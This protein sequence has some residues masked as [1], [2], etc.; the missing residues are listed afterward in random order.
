M[1]SEW[2]FCCCIQSNSEPARAFL[3]ILDTIENPESDH[4]LLYLAYRELRKTEISMQG[5]ALPYVLESLH[6]QDIPEN[7][8]SVVR[9]YLDGLVQLMG[10]DIRHAFDSFADT[11]LSTTLAQDGWATLADGAQKAHRP[12][13]QTFAPTPTPYVDMKEFI[14]ETMVLAVLLDQLRHS[15]DSA[16]LVA[17]L[18]GEEQ[19]ASPVKQLLDAAL[20]YKFGRLPFRLAVRIVHV[21]EIKPRSDILLLIENARLSVLPLEPDLLQDYAEILFLGGSIQTG[22]APRALIVGD[23]VKAS[24]D[25]RTPAKLIAGA[26][27]GGKDLDGPARRIVQLP[28]ESFKRNLPIVYWQTTTWDLACRIDESATAAELAK[29][30]QWQPLAG[31]AINNASDSRT[32]ERGELI[33]RSPWLHLRLYKPIR[34]GT[35][36]RV[37]PNASK[38]EDL[39][40]LISAGLTSVRILQHL[41]QDSPYFAAHALLVVHSSD[42]LETAYGKWLTNQKDFTGPPAGRLSQALTALALF[43]RR[44][45]GFVGR[46]HSRSVAPESFARLLDSQLFAS[47]GLPEVRPEDRDAF[48]HLVLLEQLMSWIADAFPGV[49]DQ[50]GPGRWIPLIPDVYEAF[51]HTPHD[52]RERLEAA[53]VVRFVCPDYHL[54][55][56]RQLRWQEAVDSHNQALEWM[57]LHRQILLTERDLPPEEWLKKEWKDPDWGEVNRHATH[58]GRELERLASLNRSSHVDPSILKAWRNDW[59]G[60]LNNVARPRELDRFIR[61]R[62]LELMDDPILGNSIEDQEFIALVLMEFGALYEIGRM[63]NSVYPVQHEP[64]NAPL[65]E[66][67]RQ[68]QR[69][70]IHVMCKEL[71]RLGSAPTDETARHVARD[72]RQAV[73]DLERGTLIEEALARVA[74][75]GPIRPGPEGPESLRKALGDARDEGRDQHTRQMRELILNIE[76]ENGQR[77]IASFPRGETKSYWSVQAAICDPNMLTAT[78]VFDQ[79]DTEGAVNLFESSKQEVD[80]FLRVTATEE[81]RRVVGVVVDIEET[82]GRLKYLFNIGVYFLLTLERDANRSLNLGQGDYVAL[83]VYPS[84][85]DPRRRAFRVDDTARVARLPR[86]RL[87]GDVWKVK[88]DES[89][90]SDGRGHYLQLALDFPDSKDITREIDLDLWDADLSRLFRKASTSPVRTVYAVLNQEGRWEPLDLGLIDLL[91]K[92]FGSR[93]ANIA[94]LTFINRVTNEPGDTAW[95]FSTRPGVNYK[96]YDHQFIKEDL[97]TLKQEV[98]ELSD[99]RGLLVSVMPVTQQ[100]RVFLG[101]IQMQVNDDQVESDYPC[102]K[103][104]FDKRNIEWTNLFDER[105]FAEKAGPNWLFAVDQNRVPGFPKELHVQ[106]RIHSYSYRQYPDLTRVEFFPNTTDWARGDCRSNSVKG[107]ALNLQTITLQDKS[108]ES[109]KDFFRRW[110][111]VNKGDRIFIN[112]TISEVNPDGTVIC[113]TDEDV[114]VRVDA[115]SITMRFLG[116]GTDPS[117]A[118]E[119]AAEIT[120]IP[121]AHDHP[122]LHIDQAEVPANAFADGRC[123][124]ILVG[125]PRQ[126]R[127]QAGTL[128]QVL[129][130]TGDNVIEKQLNI[131]NLPALGRVNLGSKIIGSQTGSGCQF[132]LVPLRVRARALWLVREW[133]SSDQEGLLYLG[134]I[135]SGGT[136]RAIAESKPGE[137]VILPSI[138]EGARHLAEGDGIEFERGLNPEWKTVNLANPRYFWQEGGSDYRRAWLRLGD[139]F[140]AGVCRASSPNQDILISDRPL[141]QFRASGQVDREGNSLFSLR[142]EFKFHW[143]K[144]PTRGGEQ[145][146]D[147][148]SDIWA[149]RLAEYFHHDPLEDIEGTYKQGILTLHSLKLPADADGTRWTSEVPLAQGEGPFVSGATFSESA[150][151]QLFRDEQGRVLASLR[152]VHPFS[153]ERYKAE[154]RTEFDEPERPDP[155]LIYVGPELED[156]VTHQPYGEKRHR[157]EWAYGRTLLVPESKLRY[158]D[159]PFNEAGFVLFH[160]DIVERLQFLLDESNEGQTPEQEDGK[161]ALP[162]LISIID[163]HPSQTTILYSQRAQ[164]NFVHILHLTIREDHVHIEFVEGFDADHI[165]SDRITDFFSRVRA[166]LNVDSERRLSNRVRTGVISPETASRGFEVLGRLDKEIFEGTLGTQVVFDHV[167]LSFEESDKGSSLQDGEL[168]LLRAWTIQYIDNH[169]DMALTLRPDR[170]LHPEDVGQDLATSLMLLRRRFSV[171]EDLLKRIY[172]LKGP[173]GI[174]NTACLVRLT[175]RRRWGADASMIHNMPSRAIAALRS[176]IDSSAKPVYGAVASTDNGRVRI[177]LR[178]SVEVVLPEDQVELAPYKLTDLHR[179]T[180]VRIDKA[181][182]GR[183]R[184]ALAAFGEVRYVH[185][186]ARYVVALPKTSLL[187]HRGFEDHDVGDDRFWINNPCFTVAGFPNLRVTPG[188]YNWRSSQW[189]P[190]RARDFIGF[191]ETPHPKV[192]Q[193]GLDGRGQARIGVA[194]RMPLV[195]RLAVSSDTLEVS[196]V[197][198]HKDEREPESRLLEWRFLSF[199]D[200]PAKQII[201]RGQHK[202]IYHDSTSGTWSTGD[203]VNTEDLKDRDDISTGPLFFHATD[204]ALKLRFERAQFLRFGYQAGLLIS[205]L[206]VHKRG[207]YPVAG[208]SDRGRLWVELAPGRIVELPAELVVWLIQGREIRLSDL[209]WEGFAPGDQLDL[210]VVSDGNDLFAVDRIGISNWIPGPRGAYGPQRCVLPVQ[211]VDPQNGSIRLGVG[212]F[213]ITLP[214]ARPTI[215]RQTAALYPDN[216][217]QDQD[218]LQLQPGD[219]VL[220][221]LD[222]VGKPS[223]LGFPELTPW[224]DSG[225]PEVWRYDPLAGDLRTTDAQG[226]WV[227]NMGQLRCLITS[228]GGAIPMTVEKVSESGTIVLLSR[229][230]QRMASHIPPGLSSTARVIGLLGDRRTALLRC[231]GGIMKLKIDDVISGLP[232][233]YYEEAATALKHSQASVVLRTTADGELKVGSGDQSAPEIDVEAIGFLHGLSSPEA[234]AGLICR[235]IDTGKMYWLPATHAAWTTL[236]PDQ[237][238]RIFMSTQGKAFKVALVRKERKPP[239][240]SII[241]TWDARRELSGLSV[242]GQLSVRVLEYVESE[243]DGTRRYLVESHISGVVLACDTYEDDELEAGRLIRVEVI[244]RAIG[245]PRYLTVVPVGQKRLSL[246]LPSWMLSDLPEPGQPRREIQRF[247]SAG[248]SEVKL[249]PKESVVEAPRALDDETLNQGLCAAYIAASENS[250]DHLSFRVQLAQEWIRRNRRS[251]EIDV[252][253]AIMAIILLHEGGTNPSALASLLQLD[254]ETV[255]RQ[256]RVWKQTARE[257]AQEL[258]IRSLRSMHAEVLSYL[259]LNNR[260]SR[261]RDDGLW[262]RLRKVQDRLHAPI[263]ADDIVFIREFCQAV[264]LRNES[265]LVPIADALLAAIGELPSIST[266]RQKAEISERLISIYRTLP[267]TR[268]SLQVDLQRSHLN[269][270]KRMV[271][272]IRANPLDVTLLDPLPWHAEYNE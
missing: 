107:V 251:P 74:F 169:N 49:V 85:Q 250:G 36:T 189:G 57:V 264:K 110:N 133:S 160:G 26:L 45:F 149:K 112:R 113:L 168:V 258:G 238:R 229:R 83:S 207:T 44:Q 171:R 183:F 126:S 30:W 51:S 224:P 65:K 135:M 11:V 89:F 156:P 195:G 210:E 201:A 35:R 98:L 121:H 235:A 27:A 255:S 188:S 145:P 190:P 253:Y 73:R 208:V 24:F 71:G 216:R 48:F 220:L 162:C 97:D 4:K 109:R 140:L 103:T 217:L 10:D 84:N 138:P 8:D 182:E 134:T 1:L 119:R 118:G 13:G 60:C 142:R 239:L 19:E 78:L 53:S 124:G 42:V 246:D 54:E 148:D 223:V 158:K 265:G 23:I 153:P 226:N 77:R 230:H 25:K 263:T 187:R 41:S 94:V 180:A 242:G 64:S 218:T 231:G 167:R 241:D 163:I 96:I 186:V 72:P 199:A 129:W 151:V 115:E 21:A 245:V 47:T 59:R 166:Q 206:K 155:R 80:V 147:E 193:L 20:D 9:A 150:T 272:R 232:R 222:E 269:A 161:A 95:R 92:E 165:K 31:N 179:G 211:H 86:K 100:G 99:P 181:L 33:A 117:I 236:S 5:F 15:K 40:R 132:N 128:C 196:F 233:Q 22:A 63:L 114:P 58:L 249:P 12:P 39:I 16:S 259:W 137:I 91:L 234:T 34:D 202:W 237:L 43:G 268:S 6:R 81:R 127:G 67:R 68:L 267:I 257:M 2:Y 261:R 56:D 260:E 262:Q 243:P 184:I 154:M 175:R 215:S 252:G 29:Y 14:P 270:L 123:S 164:Y 55:V 52:L 125:L 205:H 90:Y 144:T 131:S 248:A 37:Y 247:L 88:I 173:N 240:V 136:E 221:G 228:L 214:A 170:R 87:P 18:S 120:T 70:L 139:K 194:S 38:Y 244:Q 178:P 108:D 69:S 254:V 32:S 197:P 185:E 61:L 256:A 28:Q 3:S 93:E 152:R 104:P 219:V 17:W 76:L 192:A 111:N 200:G 191:M 209:Y 122:L 172:E 203:I 141:L 146:G 62:L 130:Q 174:K 212:D 225:H 159:G 271:R 66:A 198:L 204:N 143:K 213:A 116:S 102:L 79:F 177:E 50:T 105:E 101:L 82:N 227:F 75:P 46:G 176:A 157:F 266:L 106:L 7:I